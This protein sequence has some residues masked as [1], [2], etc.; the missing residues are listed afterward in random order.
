MDAPDT[1]RASV[2]RREWAFGSW[3]R[4]SIRTVAGS[5]IASVIAT[6]DRAV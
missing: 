6:Y 3:R 2:V 5:D 4:P 1:P